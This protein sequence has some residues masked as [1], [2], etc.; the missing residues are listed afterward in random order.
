MVESPQ[1]RAQA[2][3]ACL[4][5]GGLMVCFLA[6][7]VGYWAAI[8]G[9]VGFPADVLL[10][11]ES[12]FVADVTKLQT[13][14]PVYTDEK[15]NASQVYPVGAAFAT[16]AIAAL[17]GQ[18]KSVPFFRLVQVMFTLVAAL[19][20]WLSFGTMQRLVGLMRLPGYAHHGWMVCV[21]LLLYLVAVNRM[22][23]PFVHLLHP[24]ALAQ[25]LAS[26][27]FYLLLRYIE[28]RGRGTLIAMA[29]LPA[30]GFLAKQYILCFLG[31]YCIHLFL[32]DKPWSRVRTAYYLVA[33]SGMV[34]AAA[35][36]CYRLWG[37]HWVYWTFAVLR[38]H[39]PSWVWRFEHWQVSTPHLLAG[40]IGGLVVFAKPEWRLLRGPW[41]M[42]LALYGVL[43]YTGG[44]SRPANHLGAASLIAVIWFL[45]VVQHVAAGWFS[46]WGED[47]GWPLWVPMVGAS[48]MV[49]MV[50]GTWGVLFPPVKFPPQ[51]AY[52]YVAAI[53]RE[54]DGLPP[55]RVLL[56][57]GSWN[58]LA[59]GVVMKDRSTSIG[60]RGRIG[61]ADMSGMLG[62]IGS[63]SYQK[64]LLRNYHERGFWYDHFSWPKSSGVRAAL[65][66]HYRQ[67]RTIPTVEV[68]ST[69]AK[70][71]YG[72][73][74]ALFNEVTVLVPRE[75]SSE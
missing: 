27:G 72:S 3:I 43:L 18:E 64:I 74:M 4:I 25:L 29:I 50:T 15:D 31:L 40:L 17:A 19:F 51:D 35:G 61:I 60:D 47:R 39:S 49:V 38:S 71:A 10:F 13:G 1:R 20:A 12:D 23:N 59:Q 33:S 11:S 42:W 8:G 58:Y 41:L 9:S 56:E 45:V 2:R 52:R 37:A 16:N 75:Q 68:D 28:K 36:L 32:F 44:V 66:K 63:H 48:A 22:T 30:V 54:F 67:V 21:F 57:V 62:R 24:D 14:Q 46:D 26:A 65:Q 53:S 55:D 73:S 6:C 69:T 70:W 34:A 7:T 5:L